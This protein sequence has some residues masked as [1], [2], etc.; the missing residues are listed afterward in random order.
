MSNKFEFQHNERL[1]RTYFSR[2]VPPSEESK[3][4]KNEPT[5]FNF[6]NATG[7]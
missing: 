1:V 4:V 2:N 5:E 6:A 3:E 7:D